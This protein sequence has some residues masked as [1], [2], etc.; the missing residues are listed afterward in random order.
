M[1]RSRPSRPSRPA[2]PSH[3]VTLLVGVVL[4][5]AL[6]AGAPTGASADP[7]P[8]TTY[9]R[10]VD[11]AVRDPFRA[12]A[13][14]YGRGN[15][16]LEYDTDPGERVRAAAP[17]TVAFAGQVAGRLHVTVG[18]PDGVRTT[19]GPLAGIAPGLARGDAVEA[20]DVLGVAGELLLWTARIGAAYVDPA[21]L[22]DASGSLRV[23]LVPDRRPTPPR[24]GPLGPR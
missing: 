13:T 2:R 24:R 19:Y 12:P 5:V 22:L 4:A 17:G 15:R 11:A 10:P 23:R 18:H 8:P 3:P 16:G 9:E 20:G 14:R 1:P 6:L 21:V 7:G